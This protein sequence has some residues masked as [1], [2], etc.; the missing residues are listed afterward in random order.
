MTSPL[1]TVIVPVFNHWDLIPGLLEKLHGQ[2]LEKGDFELLLVDNGSEQL[3]KDL[4]LP[5][6]A[7]MLD[8]RTPGSYAAR[9]VGVRAARG[10]LLA[11]TDADCAPDPCWLQQGLNAFTEAPV[12]NHMLVAG[13]VSMEPR[14]WSKMTT[15]EV[16]DVIMGLPQERYVRRGYAVTANLFIPAA[17]FN[18]IGLFDEQ[19]FS[20]G[21]AEFCRRATSHG[22]KIR[23]HPDARVIHPA[24]RDWAELKTKQRRVTGGQVASGPLGR[25]LMYGLF[26]FLPPVRQCY[27]ALS[28]SKLT[29]WHRLS[30]CWTWCRLWMVGVIEL[31]RL[32][33][34]RSP[35]RR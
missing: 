29:L 7:R 25:R 2:V 30:T 17:A 5:E 22:W 35:E 26:S 6:W 21:D 4:A 12:G 18:E 34:G 13:G 9:N 28:T 3:P 20:G 8:C 1:V 33:A 15:S 23:Y 10:W 24:R 32:L 19:R 11:F 16:F 27:L 14:D 31:L